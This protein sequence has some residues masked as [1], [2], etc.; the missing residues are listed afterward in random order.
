MDAALRSARSRWESALRFA[1]LG[2]ATAALAWITAKTTLSRVGG[3]GAPLDDSYIHFQ[4]A[5]SIAELHPFR[6]TAAAAPTPGAT[7]LLW[8]LVLA[9]FHAI[10]FREERLVY[11]AWALGFS[12]L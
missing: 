7:S 3:P 5:R 12:A 10:G 2:V 4:Y 9:P 6:Y 8:P 11:I 1:P